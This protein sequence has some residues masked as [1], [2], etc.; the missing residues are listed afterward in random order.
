MPRKSSKPPS[1]KPVN[2]AAKALVTSGY[3]GQRRVAPRKGKAAYTRRPKHAN[4]LAW[5]T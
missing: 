1:I 5:G 4:S 3:Y 2:V